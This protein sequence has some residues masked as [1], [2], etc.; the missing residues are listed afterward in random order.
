M[1]MLRCIRGKTRKDHVR[2]Q[3]IQ[4]DAKVCQ[5]PTFLR[6]KRLNW[7]GVWRA[8]DISG[9]EKNTTS[10]E[11]WWTWSYRG[12]EEGGGLEGDG[13]TTSGKI[14][15]IW[16]DNRYDWKRT[17]LEDDGKDWPTKMWRWSLKVRG[18]IGYIFRVKNR[19]GRSWRIRGSQ[20]RG[21]LPYWARPWVGQSFSGVAAV[22]Q[23]GRQ[24]VPS[25]SPAQS[26]AGYSAPRI[27]SRPYNTHRQVANECLLVLQLSL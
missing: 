12:R 23:T 6:Q 13:S 14:W 3:V 2:N 8:T 11:K 19:E 27:P 17:V 10:Q 25:C 7:Y 16:N 18:P 4:K 5:I 22:G 1:R 26:V 21:V 15:K 24:W 20:T 9:K